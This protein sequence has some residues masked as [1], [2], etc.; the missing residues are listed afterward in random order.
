MQSV[1]LAR[2]KKRN[3]WCDNFC[4]D[5][6]Q[7]SRRKSFLFLNRFVDSPVTF[8]S[9]KRTIHENRKKKRRVPIVPRETNEFRSVKGLSTKSEIYESRAFM[10]IINESQRRKRK[11][12]YIFLFV[13]VLIHASQKCIFEC[14]N[15]RTI[16]R[17]RSRDYNLSTRCS[18]F[19]FRLPHSIRWRSGIC[20]FF[21]SFFSRE[22]AGPY[23]SQT[24][25]IRWK[26]WELTSSV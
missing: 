12:L 10:G 25:I 3:F 23:V 15:V 2:E 1:R 16:S 18:R 24:H 14:G 22:R 4:L 19:C 7:H 20:F 26:Q 5:R 11:Y 13:L 9:A 21:R 6:N 17:I 8:I